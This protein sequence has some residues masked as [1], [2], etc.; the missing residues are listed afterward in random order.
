[1]KLSELPE[2]ALS[3]YEQVERQLRSRWVAQATSLL[4]EHNSSGT[5]AE[6]LR[7]LALTPVTSDALVSWCDTAE[8]ARFVLQLAARK[9]GQ[10]IDDQ[11]EAAN[12]FELSG[13]AKRVLFRLGGPSNDPGTGGDAGGT[14]GSDLSR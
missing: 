8:G 12:I 3:D 14:A 2:L 7:S 5:M 1:M 13:E 9:A 6:H 11:L 10:N 4:R